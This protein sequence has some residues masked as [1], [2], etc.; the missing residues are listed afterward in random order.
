VRCRYATGLLSCGGT[1]PRQLSERRVI[2]VTIARL[3]LDLGVE[4][5]APC[6]GYTSPVFDDRIA[7]IGAVGSTLCIHTNIVCMRLNNIV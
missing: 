2:M 5:S 6:M 1:V 4:R 3:V 7:A